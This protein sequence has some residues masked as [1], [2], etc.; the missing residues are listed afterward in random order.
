MATFKKKHV[1]YFK[2]TRVKLW[3]EYR[4]FTEISKLVHGKNSGIIKLEKSKEPVQ[5]DSELEKKV[6]LSMD[7]CSFI[8]E[9]KTQSLE[10][11]YKGKG[12]K[13]EHKYI[14]DIQLLQFGGAII[15]VEVKPFQEMVNSTVL[16]K[17]K[18]LREYCDE[19]GYGHAIVDIVGNSF[20]TFEDLKKEKVSKEIQDQFIEFVAER[21]EVTFSDCTPFT[22]EF[23]INDKQICN[24]IWSNQRMLKYQ[25]HKIKLKKKKHI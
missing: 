5:F 7:K 12:G 22:E 8:K 24:I 14:P 1:F 2:G 15:I 9:I 18:A 6:L 4:S 20:Y 13:K 25:Q 3:E 19:Y 10:I 23:D 21:G 16:R 17:S 11:I